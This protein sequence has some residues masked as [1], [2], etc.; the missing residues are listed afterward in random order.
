[1]GKTFTEEEMRAIMA[2]TIMI[3]RQVA[4]LRWALQHGAE[5]KLPKEIYDAGMAMFQTLTQPQ[6]PQQ[7]PDDEGQEE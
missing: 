3:D 6:Q 4:F 2:Q 5:A 7:H 1:M